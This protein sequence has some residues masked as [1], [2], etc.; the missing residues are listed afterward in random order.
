[1]NIGSKIRNARINASLTQEQAAEALGVSRQT[2]S[3]WENEKT[4]P[5]IISVIRMSDLYSVSL[6]LLLKEEKVVSD[7]MNYLEESTNTVKIKKK[8]SGI[9]LVIAYVIIWSFCLLS[10]WIFN[11]NVDAMVF[12]LL[13]F[14]LILPVSSFIISLI[15]GKNGLWGKLKWHSPVFFGVMFMLA[16]CGT[17]L[18]ANSLA[19]SKLNMPS[20]EM[21]VYGGLISLAGL[22]IG[23]A[24]NKIKLRSKD[25]EKNEKI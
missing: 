1:M 16:D 17:Y 11:S 24:V 21:I 18:L 3:N 6:D 20:W 14:W 25:I 23:T 22:L 8:H 19:F 15:V 4:Y 12:G 2:I 7:Y 9:V 5:D 10:F 13:V